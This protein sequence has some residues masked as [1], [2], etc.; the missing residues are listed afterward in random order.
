MTHLA[1]LGV[2]VV[3]ALRAS[4]SLTALAAFRAAGSSSLA[5]RVIVVVGLRAAL[6]ALLYCKKETA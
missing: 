5:L 2:I 3:G 1:A 4:F 6:A